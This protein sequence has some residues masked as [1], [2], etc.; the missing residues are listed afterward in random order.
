MQSHGRFFRIL[1]IGRRKLN[2]EETDHLV[3]KSICAWLKMAIGIA[4][5]SGTSCPQIQVQISSVHFQPGP[6]INFVTGQTLNCINHKVCHMFSIY[7]VYLFAIETK[8]FSMLVLL[9]PTEA[10]LFR[11]FLMK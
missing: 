1:K 10:Y 6:N 11:D 4:Q 8:I 2:V 9:W 7:F 3:T 5:T